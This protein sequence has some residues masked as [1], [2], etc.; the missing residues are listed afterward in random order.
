VITTLRTDRGE[1]TMS[2]VISSTS[3]P[4]MNTAA[5]YLC[6]YAWVV[7]LVVVLTAAGF[8]HDL[9]LDVVV[10]VTGALVAATTVVAVGRGRS[11]S[12][13]GN[14]KA[15]TQLESNPVSWARE[16]TVAVPL[17]SRRAVRSGRVYVSSL[18][19]PTPVRPTKRRRKPRRAGRF[20][21]DIMDAELRGMMTRDLAAGD[22]DQ[23]D[24]LD[25]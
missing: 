9:D 23:D 15:G 6:L 11:T 18:N 1:S 24:D 2:D 3:R 21:R 25:V 16:P 14:P 19:M 22:D 8:N 4:A 5:A 20:D 12:D 13:A 10:V 17:V 7:W